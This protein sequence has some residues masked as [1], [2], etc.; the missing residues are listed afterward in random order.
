MDPDLALSLPRSHSPRIARIH[1]LRDRPD[2]IPLAQGAILRL[3]QVVASPA[4][5]EA[6]EVMARTAIGRVFDGWLSLN[7]TY[8]P[9]G[10]H[11]PAPLEQ[12]LDPWHP[13]PEPSV[14]RVR[15]LRSAGRQD[16]ALQ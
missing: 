3:A 6:A 13:A 16:V 8:G 7:W 4:R 1:A 5:D 11:Q 2:A 9:S 14:E 10:R 15:F 12:R